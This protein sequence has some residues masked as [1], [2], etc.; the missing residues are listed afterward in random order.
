MRVK[1]TRSIQ[2]FD[3]FLGSEETTEFSMHM[4]TTSL[5]VEEETH[6]FSLVVIFAF[7]LL[8]LI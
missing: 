7:Y 2:R 8:Y 1:T 3:C 6:N 5:I 4:S